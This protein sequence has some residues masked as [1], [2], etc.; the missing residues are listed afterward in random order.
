M[1]ARNRFSSACRLRGFYVRLRT[2]SAK[3]ELVAATIEVHFSSRQFENR[4]PAIDLFVPCHEP[5][6][7]ANCMK[8]IFLFSISLILVAG[9]SSVRTSYDFDRQADFSKYKTFQF[10]NEALALPVNDLVRK[11]ITVAIASNLQSKGFT[12]S[13]NADLL[14]DLGTQTREEQQTTATSAN[15]S[16]FYGR[17]WSFGTGVASTQYNTRT[18]TVGTLIV[19]LVDAK[20]QELVWEGRG[21]STV[22]DKNLQA[23]K[24]EAGIG[25]I[26]KTFPPS[27]NK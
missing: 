9:C 24:L 27:V 11:R 7:L 15:L 8:R 26:L 18:Y 20:K 16:G 10:T 22:S 13:D 3:D 5:K 12:Q 17:R 25:Q 4:F 21:T 1:G 19:S 14:V 2:S 23:E 6:A